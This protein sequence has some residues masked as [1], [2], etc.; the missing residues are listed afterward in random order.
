MAERIR[1]G[2]RD[3]GRCL[4]RD[5]QARGLS[6][7]AAAELIGIHPIQLA[8]IEAASANFTISTLFAIGTAYKLDLSALFST[9]ASAPRINKKPARKATKASVRKS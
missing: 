5:R 3:L 7:E 2:R 8:R 9:A 4:R 1:V 6:R